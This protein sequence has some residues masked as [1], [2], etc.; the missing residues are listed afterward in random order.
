M[1]GRTKVVSAALIRLQSP[2]ADLGSKPSSKC[3]RTF[4]GV[5]GPVTLSWTAIASGKSAVLTANSPGSVLFGFIGYTP[6]QADGSYPY[7]NV[8]KYSPTPGF[9][10]KYVNVT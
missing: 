8:G 10:S 7:T 6:N 3:A 1:P 2:Q 5:A 9:I 4:H